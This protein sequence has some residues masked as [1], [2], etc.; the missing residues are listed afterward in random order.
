MSKD[1]SL[2]GDSNKD[3]DLLSTIARHD[4]ARF[5]EIRQKIIADFMETVPEKS[6][7]KLNKTQWKI[8]QIR[9]LAKNPIDAYLKISAFMWESARRLNEEQQ[10]LLS[11]MSN[12]YRQESSDEDTTPARTAT[13]LQFK[14]RGTHK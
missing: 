11:E 7:E 5:E 9:Q 4:K 13:I 3:H 1:F 2:S 10:K 6:A 12:D 14:P 8:D